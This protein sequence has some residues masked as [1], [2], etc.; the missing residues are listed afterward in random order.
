MFRILLC[1]NAYIYIFGKP[2]PPEGGMGMKLFHDIIQMPH[3][4]C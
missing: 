4:V 2:L 3:C 1:T